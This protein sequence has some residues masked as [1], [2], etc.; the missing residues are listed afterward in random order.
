M[1]TNIRDMPST[2]INKKPDV[3]IDPENMA[4]QA[5]LS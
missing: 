2:I 4:D 3:R 5:G 1:C